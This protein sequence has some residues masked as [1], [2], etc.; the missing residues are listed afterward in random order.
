MGHRFGGIGGHPVAAAPCCKAI[1]SALVCKPTG[2][3][4]QIGVV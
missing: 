1:T 4:R 2:R 3:G